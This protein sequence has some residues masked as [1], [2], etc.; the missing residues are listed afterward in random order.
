[1]TTI[2]AIAN[3]V[4]A[5][6]AEQ[7]IPLTPSEFQAAFCK[8]LSA[9]GIEHEDCDK[10]AKT[11][12]KLNE[13]YQKI[14]KTYR[15]RTENEL[16]QFFISQVNRL[17][18]SEAQIYISALSSLMHA[19][20]Q[21]VEKLKHNEATKLSLR[22]ADILENHKNPELFIALKTEW[23]ALS[24]SDI[25]ALFAPLEEQCKLKKGSWE[26][27]VEQL[28]HC[29]ERQ[30]FDIECVSTLLLNALAPSISKSFQD[31]LSLIKEQL[32][33]NPQL[34]KTKS[35]QKEIE[36]LISRRVYIDNKE[37][38]QRIK[39][40]DAIIDTVSKKLSTLTYG[41]AGG[42]KKL[43][44]IKEFIDKMSHDKDG[45]D[46]VKAKLTAL[47]SSLDND[48]TQLHNTIK[49]ESSEIERL[50]EQVQKLERELEEVKEEVGVDF[51]TKVANRKALE[52][53]LHRFEELYLRFGDD[54]A[55]L[56]FDLDFFKQINDK[57]GH[58]A[59]DIVLSSFGT[60]LKK[61]SRDMDIVGRYGGEEFISLLPKADLNGAATFA[62]KIRSAVEN[63][64]FVYKNQRIAV[65][66][67]CGIAVRSDFDSAD[68]TIKASDNRLY[69][70]KQNGRNRVEIQE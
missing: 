27:I 61:H 56:F 36:R 8:E 51:L 9:A 55:I 60:L 16:L 54:Y 7:K 14:L 33:Q 70:A 34:I 35:T 45:F 13:N 66:V 42:L 19:V 3:K 4:I 24:K 6:L 47:V 38:R 32:K 67:S 18:P 37:V 22:T 44:D 57:F 39:D 2:E 52:E 53:E 48:M 49:E 23:D 25:D 10:V 21:T 17:N 1:M 12:A 68:S 63:T 59:G 64:K 65:T 50:R 58:L 41:G 29:N 69:K 15:V 31:E 11:T 5:K 43:A 30:K 40:I 26:L 28:L 62:E 20:L 46:A